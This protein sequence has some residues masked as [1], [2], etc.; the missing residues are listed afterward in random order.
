MEDITDML[1]LST[2]RGRALACAASVKIYKLLCS[3][4]AKLPKLQRHF[5]KLLENTPH[6]LPGGDY[7]II[8]RHATGAK[9]VAC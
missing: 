2:M 4:R 1:N 6:V 5:L 8:R 7:Y 9:W 3:M